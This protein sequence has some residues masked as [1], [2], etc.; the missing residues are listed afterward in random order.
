MI[1]LGNEATKTIVGHQIAP[2]RH[3]WCRTFNKIG[4]SDM[5]Q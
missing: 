3:R 5:K 2:F 4:S 1:Q